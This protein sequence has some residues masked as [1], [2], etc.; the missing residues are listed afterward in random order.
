MCSEGASHKGG[1]ALNKDGVCE[2]RCSKPFEDVRY[3][4]EGPKYYGGD[5]ID[6][7]PAPGNSTRILYVLWVCIIL[8][9]KCVQ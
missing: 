1:K 2:Y 6:C 5:S 3:C 4:G 9:L 8:F 7:Q